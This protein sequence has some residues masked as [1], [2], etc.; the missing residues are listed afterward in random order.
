MNNNPKSVYFAVE[1]CVNY[2]THLYTLAQAGFS[3]QPYT[4]EFALSVKPQD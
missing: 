1:F 3:D 2:L 4:A